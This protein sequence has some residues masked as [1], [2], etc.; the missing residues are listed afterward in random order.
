MNKRKASSKRGGGTAFVPGIVFRTLFKA[1]IPIV[2]STV[3][4]A[5]LALR[6]Y[7]Y[8]SGVPGHD[9]SKD[10]VP[11][12]GETATK[13]DAAGWR[14]ADVAVAHDRDGAI[15]ATDGSHGH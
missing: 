4:P 14:N 3:L 11:D 15:G 1:T 8:D 7:H 10:L 13:S 2:S 5:C 12:V 9:A 6:A